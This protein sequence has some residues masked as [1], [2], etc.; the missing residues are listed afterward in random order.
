MITFVIPTRNN[1]KYIKSAYNSIRK[2]YSQHEII[3]LD[4]NST[5]GTKTWLSTLKDNNLTT[6]YHKNNNHVGHVVL[7][8]IGI[9][10]SKNSIVSIFH[11]DMRCGPNYVENLLK[12]WSPKSVISATRIEP[13]LHPIGKEK[14]IQNFGEDISEFKEKEFL[15][16]CHK[17]QQEET[18]KITKGIFAPWLIHKDDFLSIG[19][20]DKYLS[21]QQYEDS[22]LF[23]RFILA[24]YNI[25]QSRDSFVYH[26]TCRGCR[27]ENWNKQ[28]ENDLFYKLCCAKN[29]VHF[30]R[31][32]GHWI[33]NDENCYPI[34]H[35]KFDV[36]VVINNC[37]QQ[38]ISTI[39]PWF[40]TIY[41]DCPTEHYIEQVQPGTPF[42]IHQRIKKINVDFPINDIIITL[43]GNQ[44]NNERLKTLTLLPTMIEDSGEE[45]EM[46]YDIFNIKINKLIDLSS[47]LINS[48]SEWYKNQMK[49]IDG[50]PYCTDELFRVFEQIK[51]KNQ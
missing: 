46:E 27:G 38:I 8:D 43:D 5:D 47:N 13:P 21:P 48:S 15:D 36:G 24:G 25:K 51:S 20:H 32:W 4:D 12:Y 22:D 28:K 7:Y 49:V 30:I 6:Y 33:Q 40:S 9:K 19:G 44:L 3:I 10:M 17:K 1:E 14:I 26:F 45:G 29:M 31:K 50:D 16:F 2:Y 35:K 37:P 39:E 18:N 34:I 23:Q 41:V 11:A 42:N